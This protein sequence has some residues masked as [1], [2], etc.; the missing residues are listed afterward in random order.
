MIRIHR[1]VATLAL[2][3]L[4]ACGQKETAPGAAT[5]ATA[6]T[7]AKSSPAY[8]QVA[9]GHQ[10]ACALTGEG[11]LVCWGAKTSLGLKVGDKQPPNQL[12]PAPLAALASEKVVSVVTEFDSTCVITDAE[13]AH[14]WQGG[15]DPKPAAKVSGV[16]GVK[17]LDVGL[18]HTCAVLE[19]GT[20]RCWGFNSDGSLGGGNAEFAEGPVTVAGVAKAV[21]AGA[22]GSHSCARLE[23]GKVVCW[24]GHRYGQLGDGNKKENSLEPVEVAGITDAAQLSVH[25]DGSCVRHATGA[26]SCW[27]QLGDDDTGAPKKVEGLPAVVDVDVGSQFACAREQ[28]GT[29]WCWGDIET[30]A[31]GAATDGT[32]P[33]VGPTKVATLKGVSDVDASITAGCAITASGQSVHCW[34]S[35]DGGCLGDGSTVLQLSPVQ[36]RGLDD[37]QTMAIEDG[38]SCALKKDG[39]VACWGCKREGFFADGERCDVPQRLQGAAGVKRIGTSGG[40][41]FAID[42]EGKIVRWLWSGGKTGEGTPIKGVDNVVEIGGWAARVSAR[43]EDGRAAQVWL[44]GFDD[45]ATVQPFSNF[46]DLTTLDEAPCSGTCRRLCGLRKDGTI[47]CLRYRPSRDAKPAKTAMRADADAKNPLA[48]VTVIALG[49][50]QSCAATKDGKAHCW[51]NEPDEG[52]I[53]PTEVAGLTDAAEIRVDDEGSTRC[54]RKTSG[55]VLCWT[56]SYESKGKLGIGYLADLKTPTPVPGITDAKELHMSGDHVCVVHEGG[57][58]SCWGS[59]D[60]DQVGAEKSPRAYVP[61]AVAF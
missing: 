51:K 44:R 34:G 7:T 29:L 59:N 50:R 54:A 3:A 26:V 4:A 46:T 12:K 61:V 60:R 53:T 9:I 47:G 23:T 28:N 21:E 13:E 22:G 57:K 52:D 15:V 38:Y 42:G 45:E 1:V 14:C 40:F 55:E 6:T 10:H 49:A 36:V 8:V 35:A 17:H 32:K 48:D 43:L 37:V 39:T 56:D 41:V 58:V 25:G 11:K 2:T 30:G 33:D 24:G 5:M 16:A 19:D 31:I 18:S 27:G 20:M